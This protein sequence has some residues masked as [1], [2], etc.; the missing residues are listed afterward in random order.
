MFSYL[1]CKEQQK[2][3]KS[4][5]K[6][7]T[8]T[9][10]QTPIGVNATQFEICTQQ[11]TILSTFTCRQKPV[12]NRNISKNLVTHGRVNVCKNPNNTLGLLLF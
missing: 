10:I 12:H 8:S 9:D 3:N 4:E 6:Y 5:E 11:Q 7:I 1:C 2:Y